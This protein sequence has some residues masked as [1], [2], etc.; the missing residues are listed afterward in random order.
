MGG[1]KLCRRGDIRQGPEG[2]GSPVISPGTGVRIQE[3]CVPGSCWRVAGTPG[4]LGLMWG[5]G[6]GAGY[7]YGQVKV[8]PHCGVLLSK[9]RGFFISCI[10]TGE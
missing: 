3:R 9:G 2:S 6:K 10:A 8:R 7:G 5:E 4:R 1:A